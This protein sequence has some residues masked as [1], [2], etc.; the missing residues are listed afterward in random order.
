MESLTR[1]NTKLE[2]KYQKQSIKRCGDVRTSKRG[3]LRAFVLILVH[4]LI[5]IHIAQWLI[6]GET[7]TPLEPSEAM[8][9]LELGY[10][11]AGF[12]LF[13]IA[14]LA[15]LIFGRF[16]CGW[17]CHVVAYQDLCG[18]IMRKLGRKP[19]PFRSRLLIYVPLFAALYMFVWPQ[20]LRIWE[21]RPF[22]P[23][24]YHLTTQHFWD[25]FPGFWI[26]A[27]TFIVCGGL[28]VYLLGNKGFCTYG[29][30][31][32][33]FFAPADRLA[34][35]KIRVTDACEQCGHCTTVCTSNVRVHEEVNR[36]GMVVDPGC[37]KCMDCVSVCPKNALY[38][39]FGKP[40]LLTK[41]DKPAKHK[42]KYDFT[43]F[44]ELVMA[45]IFIFSFYA[46]RGLYD[47]IPLLLSIALSGI[48]AYLSVCFL[49]V[50][51]KKN[52]RLQ[53]TQLSNQDGITI[54]GQLFIFLS[55]LLF[56]FLMHSSI[57]Q[58]HWHQANAMIAQLREKRSKSDESQLEAIA[59]SARSHLEWCSNNGFFVTAAVETNLGDLALFMN[60]FESAV[61]YLEKA[62]KLGAPG[63][64]PYYWLAQAYGH[65]GKTQEA[66][67]TLKK[68]ISINPSLP[69]VRKDLAFA[70]I[71]V[72][73]LKEAIKQ[74]RKFLE[75]D[76]NDVESLTM[77][78]TLLSHEKQYEEAIEILE[79]II[80]RNPDMA[81]PYF[82]LGNIYS[83]VGRYDEAFN[84]FTQST[85]LQSNYVEAY[86]EIATVEVMRGNN[87]NAITNA[88]KA[89][90]ISPYN[91]DILIKWANIMEK[92]SLISHKIKELAQSDPEDDA[93][94]YAITF[95]YK[96]KGDFKTA[97]S[98]FMRLLSRK[99][100]LT[101][102]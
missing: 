86:A 89:R 37:M 96:Q 28:M 83:K 99:P 16:F 4:I 51:R 54:Y 33:G 85:K 59:S 10:I 64:E 78:A 60:D 100:G 34:T 11:N 53:R 23:L 35:G 77:F 97:N 82:V 92:T 73:D 40:S 57:W 6:T 3:I 19:K 25:T 22:P 44:E 80:K 70:Y 52:V 30:P 90:K 20:I 75:K 49:R 14:I 62:I 38:F 56:I 21:G 68:S 18:W 17:A 101:P 81:Q 5:I 15:T 93:S 65:L 67:A 84:A 69:G 32:G 72:G 27:L 1:N 91:R 48:S 7:M 12:I 31:Y 46:F 88:E 74:F 63:G 87:E 98:L 45:V 66:I 26:G 55:F 94:W 42:K 36:Y 13:L 39:G 61:I 79:N 43:I 58:Y 2:E 29:C 95:L 47:A 24:V 71:Q 41:T 50:V 8:Q 102:P 76:S 9:T